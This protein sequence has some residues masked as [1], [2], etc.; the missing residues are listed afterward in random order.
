MI[1]SNTKINKDRGFTIVELL[2]VIVIIGILA[3]ITIVSYTGITQR[4]NASKIQSNANSV[5]KTAEAFFADSNNYYPG[6]DAT[7]HSA[8]SVA[9]LPASI[10]IQSDAAS[11]PVVAGWDTNYSKVA[12]SCVTAAASCAA[13]DTAKN[14]TGLRI[15][16]WDPTGNGSKVYLYVGNATAGSTYVY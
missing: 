1:L 16:Y 8:T 3:A 4:A 5:M 13:G 7:F 14:I 2:I 12:V 9:K 15:A 10:T 6:T 11:S